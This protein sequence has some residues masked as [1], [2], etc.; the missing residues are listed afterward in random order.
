MSPP[1]PEPE[2][3][4]ATDEAAAPHRR[5]ERRWRGGGPRIGTRVHRKRRIWPEAIGLS[6]LAT[7]YLV[8]HHV[9]GS[10]H[11]IHPS[12][13]GWMQWGVWGVLAFFAL[14]IAAVPYPANSVVRRRLR[15]AAVLLAAAPIAAR[16]AGWI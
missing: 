11:P 5:L 13:M 12:E 6:A 15:G 8:A 16:F 1:T 10:D 4:R 14:W 3:E 2:P 7:A 9:P